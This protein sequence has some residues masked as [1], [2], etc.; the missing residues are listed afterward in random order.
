MKL[1]LVR[2]GET[3]WNQERRIQG[4]DSDIELNNTGLEQARRL[5]TFLQDEN[6]ISILSSP[7]RRA[8]ATAQAIA[9]YHRLSIEVDQGLRELRVGELEGM[10]VSNFNTTFNHFLVQWW[11]HSWAMKLPNGESFVE[12]QQ[13]AWKVVERLLGKHE[14]NSERNEDTS[15]IIVSH[16][17]VTIAIILKALNLPPEYLTKFKVDLGGVS[18]LEI[19]DHE[20]RLVTFNDTSY[21]R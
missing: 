6:V 19:H 10:S 15:V 9:S 1:V 8:T 7:L 18:K 20:A 21:Q 11:Q 17:F 3:W 13:R 4:G 16:Y 14:A 2:H 12:L 5:A